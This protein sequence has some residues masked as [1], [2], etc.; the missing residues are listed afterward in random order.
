MMIDMHDDM[1]YD[2]YVYYVPCRHNSVIIFLVTNI[3]ITPRKKLVQLLQVCT[4]GSSSNDSSSCTT[5]LL[6]SSSNSNW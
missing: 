4:H 2:F 3:L 6:V 5:E 1:I